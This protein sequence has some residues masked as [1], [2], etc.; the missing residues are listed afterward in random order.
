VRRFR[1]RNDDAVDAYFDADDAVADRVAEDAAENENER[2]AL[3]G[4][5]AQILG[6]DELRSEYSNFLVAKITRRER[7]KARKSE[8]RPPQLGPER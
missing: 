8:Q 6:H 1:A 4:K 5:K 2:R 3:Q 7:M